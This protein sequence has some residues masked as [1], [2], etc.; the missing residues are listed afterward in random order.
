MYALYTSHVL[1][2]TDRHTHTDRQTGHVTDSGHHVSPRPGEGHSLT[3]I[4]YTCCTFTST[5]ED[6][7]PSE[8]GHLTAGLPRVSPPAGA[9]G[10][11]LQGLQHVT[12][13]VCKVT[14]GGGDTATSHVAVSPLLHPQRRHTP[15]RTVSPQTAAS[16]S[17]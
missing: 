14:Y 3:Y 6:A 5:A 12:R 15:H 11:P 4:M 8:R 13:T 1:I 2:H 16:R 17:V 9:V 10:P 7:S